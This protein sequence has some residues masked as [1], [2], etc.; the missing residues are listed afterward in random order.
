MVEKAGAFFVGK[1]AARRRS[2]TLEE[3]GFIENIPG[4][5]SEHCLETGTQILKIEG[6][7]QK[8]TWEGRVRNGEKNSVVL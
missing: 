7:A 8:I 5:L 2:A 6:T 1:R 3:R 4:A